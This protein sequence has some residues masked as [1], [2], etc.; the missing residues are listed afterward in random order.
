MLLALVCSRRADETTLCIDPVEIGSKFLT[1]RD[2]WCVGS[3]PGAAVVRPT[4][5]DFIQALKGRGR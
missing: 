1:M 3:P 2:A 4:P 5:K